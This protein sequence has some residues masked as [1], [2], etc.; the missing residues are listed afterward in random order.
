M[1]ATSK[2][3]RSSEEL[4]PLKQEFAQWR[5]GRKVGERIPVALW[6][7]AS[8]AAAEHGAYRVAVELHLDYAELKRRATRTAGTVGAGALAPRFV[9][10]FTPHGT[11][12]T[13]PT[14]PPT[15]T[16]QPGRPAQ[17]PQA[18]PAPCVIEMTNARGAS[19]RVE[20]NGCALAGL[21][22]VCSA[23]WAAP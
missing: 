10:L 13:A 19:M 15:Q 12:Q 22:S 8:E 17:P 20:L 3:R 11:V 23:F 4:S 6:A 14:V 7:Q 9:E 16:T 2:T 21:S 5:A 18:L 1:D